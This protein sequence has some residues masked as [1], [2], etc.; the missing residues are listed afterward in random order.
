MGSVNIY[1]LLGAIGTI[2]S[3]I[4]AYLGYQK[5]LKKDVHTEGQENGELKSDIEYIKRRT[6]E[7]LL[8][9]KD[10]NKIIS[11]HADRLARVEESAKQAHK[12]ID[13]L[14]GRVND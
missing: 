1:V 11:S 2:C 10:I 8:E 7:T 3:I 9:V 13:R 12:R 5:G 6:E 14:E 4:F